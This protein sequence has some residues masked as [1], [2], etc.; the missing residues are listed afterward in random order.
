MENVG[1]PVIRYFPADKLV[2]T[3]NNFKDNLI[4]ESNFICKQQYSSTE[5]MCDCWV[6]AKEFLPLCPSLKTSFNAK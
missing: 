5:Q 4:N 6:C 3:F 2:H 1:C